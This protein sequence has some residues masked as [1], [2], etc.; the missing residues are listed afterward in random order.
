MTQLLEE[1]TRFRHGNNPSSLD[2]IITE[3]PELH[4]SVKVSSPIGKPDHAVV[5]TNLQIT[6]NKKSENVTKY[7]TVFNFA[8]TDSEIR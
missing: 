1:P 7:Q 4:S 8:Q 5:T 3:D 6:I 2:L